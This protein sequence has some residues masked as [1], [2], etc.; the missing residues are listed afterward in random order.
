MRWVSER[1]TQARKSQRTFWCGSFILS[2]DVI[3][4]QPGGGPQLRGRAPDRRAPGDPPHEQLDL[5]ALRCRPLSPTAGVQNGPRQS[6]RPG[7]QPLRPLTHNTRRCGHG[8]QAVPPRVRRQRRCSCPRTPP[9]LRLGGGLSGT[10]GCS[11]GTPIPFCPLNPRPR[12]AGLARRAAPH[13]SP[14]RQCRPFPS[15]QSAS[16]RDYSR[17]SDAAG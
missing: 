10:I 11:A 8:C 6:G 4:L 1:G 13:G 17:Y 7:A 3:L 2:Q 5:I 16:R 9:Y 12:C 14:A 15:V